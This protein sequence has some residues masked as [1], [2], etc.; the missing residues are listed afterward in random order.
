MRIIYSYTR[1]A[2]IIGLLFATACRQQDNDLQ[3]EDAQIGFYNASEYIRL[4]LKNTPKANYLFVD[5][6]DTVPSGAVPRFTNSDYINQFPNKFYYVNHPQPWLSY[7]R[8]A[9]G[10]HQ[11]ILRDTSMRRTLVIDTV[12]SQHGEPMTVYFADDKGKFRTWKLSDQ[13]NTKSDSIYLR[14]LNLSPDAGKVFLTI[15]GKVPTGLPASLDYG[16]VT[17]F[18]G[19]AVSGPDTLRVRFY[20]QSA[21]DAAIISATLLTTPGSAYNIVLKGN[22]MAQSFKDPLTG[23]VLN[24]DAS[25]KLALTQVK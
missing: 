11:L 9:P 14:I 12:L 7:I 1:L 15:N 21:P 25:L 22:L 6:K 3:P 8:V 5:T 10:A 19:R 17:R 13:V 4:Q 16:D 2:V 24:Y 20:Q 23:L 18:T